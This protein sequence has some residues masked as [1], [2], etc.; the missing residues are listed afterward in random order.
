MIIAHAL[1]HLGSCIESITES[2]MD[3]HG[4]NLTL[5]WRLHAYSLHTVV[6]SGVSEY[7]I[8]VSPLFTLLS[9]LLL[10]TLG[11]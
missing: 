2:M 8:S 5:I 9:F 7:I 4:I 10:Y 11:S 6:G 1:R 3:R